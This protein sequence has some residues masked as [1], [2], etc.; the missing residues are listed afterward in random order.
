MDT[1]T[2]VSFLYAGT[3]TLLW[4]IYWELTKIR[5]RLVPSDHD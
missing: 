3:V 4:L 2:I 5:E 1:S